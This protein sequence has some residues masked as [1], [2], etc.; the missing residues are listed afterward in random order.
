MFHAIKYKRD[1]NA[2][3][4]IDWRHFASCLLVYG[5]QLYAPPILILG[6]NHDSVH[7]SKLM[8]LCFYY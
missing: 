5:D 6:L 3:M 2:H 8:Y 4:V 1:Y 7:T